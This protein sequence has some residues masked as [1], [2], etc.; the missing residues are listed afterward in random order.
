MLWLT[1]I[2]M[3]TGIIWIHGK[4]LNHLKK[5]DASYLPVHAFAQIETEI[6]LISSDDLNTVGA[7]GSGIV[8]YVDNTY[9]YVLT[10]NHV[11]TPPF[12]ERVVQLYGNETVIVNSIVD[13]AGETRLAEVVY[14]D[15]TKDL[16]I[17]KIEGS[18]TSP[19]PL[20]LVAP[21]IGDRIYS[22]AAPGG[23]FY[24]GVVPIFD[25]IYSGKIN[26][27]LDS[28]DIYTIPTQG[29]SSG[30]AVLNENFEIIGVI[31]SSVYGNDN[32]GIASTHE[33]VTEFLYSWEVLF[34]FRVH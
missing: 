13:Y 20:S 12:H 7:Q 22:L 29:G 25:G 19:V 2:L 4:Q 1:T 24:P 8:F 6:L 17:L 33:E 11:C 18:W 30:A 3:M 14:N 27:I 28:D 31:H 32:I 10:A 26:S 5:L 16:C 34:G 9:T 21:E 23:F 15:I